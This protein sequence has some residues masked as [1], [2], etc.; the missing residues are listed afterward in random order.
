MLLRVGADCALGAIHWLR[1][2][3][4]RTTIRRRVGAALA[5]FRS[6]AAIL[7][8]AAVLLCASCGTERN[9]EKIEWTLEEIEGR[10]TSWEAVGET[11]GEIVLSRQ[12]IDG[13]LSVFDETILYYRDAGCILDTLEEVFSPSDD[14]LMWTIDEILRS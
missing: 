2:F 9:V 8:A 7:C 11:A 14:D 4:M 12:G 13:P 5:G 1:F 10:T 3:A 6:R